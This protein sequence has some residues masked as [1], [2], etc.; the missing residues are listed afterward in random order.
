MA[1]LA[2]AAALLAASCA[3]SSVE[4]PKDAAPRIE[5]RV[6]YDPSARDP[7]WRVEIRA[8][9]LAGARDL[10]LHLEDWG[11][12]M[13]VDAYYLR[14]LASDPPLRPRDGARADFDVVAPPGWSGDLRTSYALATAPLGAGARERHGLLPYRAP[15]YSLGFA[16]NTLMELAWDGRPDGLAQ[17]LVVE[18]PAAW[19]VATG[20]AGASSGRQVATIPVAFGNTVISFGVPR[21]V[22]RS[23]EGAFPVEVVQWG[24]EE[25]RSAALLRFATAYVRECAASTGSPPTGPVRLIVAEPGMGGTRVDGAIAIGWP[26]SLDGDGGT[27]HFVAHEVFHDWL[28]GHLRSATGDESLCWFWE[29]F[30]DYL[31]LWHLA[32]A[33]LVSRAWFA[34]RL[35]S[36]DEIASRV[37]KRGEVAYASA[38]VAWRDPEIEPL[39]YQGSALVAFS[40]DVALRRAGREGLATI[41]RDFMN[42]PGRRYRLA[43]I[44][45]WLESHGLAEI[46]RERFEKPAPRT[47]EAD[48]LAIGFVERET[49]EPLTYLGLQLDADGPFG[50]VASVDPDGP[51]AGLVRVGDRVTGLTPTRERRPRFRADFASSHRFGLDLYDPAAERVRVDVVREG[52]RREIWVRPRVIDGGV[53]K[54]LVPDDARVDAFF[55]P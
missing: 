15:T 45:E 35:Q 28:G 53:L 13:Q 14:D 1:R 25:D 44:R 32:K 47:L 54:T 17:T 50:T 4:A 27:L 2:S 36:Y 12:W 43:D 21:A 46:W 42:L 48:L 55:R 3:A 20:F 37:A 18:A 52:E 38:G 49:P 29:G 7:A 16:A 10:H 5:T 6:A 31:A 41:V 34:K 24:G 33:G 11:E 8:R 40:I 51:A 9:G 26:E 30:T 19:T 22:A 39:A 23:T